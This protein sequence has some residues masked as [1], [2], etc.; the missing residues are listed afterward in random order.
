MKKL[1]RKQIQQLIVLGLLF[2]AALSYAAYQLLFSGSTGASTKSSVANTETAQPAAAQE[3]TTTEPA[4]LTASEPA[5]DPFV[6]PPQFDN[7]KRTQT[8]NVRSTPVRTTSV[9]NVSALPPM[10]VAPV[11][12]TPNNVSNN[13]S[14][15]SADT[16]APQQA[17]DPQ[18]T[19]TGVVIGERPVAIVRT[20]GNDQRIV[21]PGHQ[22][23]GGYILR[24]VSREGVVME[25]DGKT[26][27][28]RPG[29]NPNAK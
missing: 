14:T 29:G 3:Q 12:G 15:P 26:V 11:S 10:P 13:V 28:L 23:E 21:Q 22:M 19:V 5:R 8:A 2:I 6:V 9:P 20:E 27:T 17:P 7:L 1:D 4:W 16:T 25:K 24:T 18:I